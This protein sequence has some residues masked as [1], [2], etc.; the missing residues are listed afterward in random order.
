MTD[1][2]RASR[3]AARTGHVTATATPP[4]PASLSANMALI[5][6]KSRPEPAAFISSTTAPD[7]LNSDSILPVSAESRL[8]LDVA[9]PPNA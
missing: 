8:M 1:M 4:G 9:V 2:L 7:H 6:A 3:R 5:P